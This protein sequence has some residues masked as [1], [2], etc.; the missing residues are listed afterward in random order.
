MPRRV[1]RDGTSR[2]IRL[3][4]RGLEPEDVALATRLRSSGVDPFTLSARVIRALDADLD[5]SD[6]ETQ[7]ALGEAL[8]NHDAKLN[9]LE[10]RVDTRD[11]ELADLK[12]VAGTARWIVNGILAAAGVL[13]VY[14]LDRILTRAEREG[15]TTI[16]LQ[17]IERTLDRIQDRRP[18]YP[19][20]PIAQQPPKP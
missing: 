6:S 14:V 13:G 2:L 8:R 15:E 17:V 18:D 19:T 10:N 3:V 7:T 20:V 11:T 5:S 12:R 9:R 4:E 16:R 1:E